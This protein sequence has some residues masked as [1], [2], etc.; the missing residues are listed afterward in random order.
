MAFQTKKSVLAVTVEATE[1]TYLAPSSADDFLPIQEDFSVE[2]AFETLEN[3]ELTGSIGTAKPI[4]GFEVPTASL[5]LYVK[6]SA[7]EGTAPDA[8]DL[9]HAAFGAKTLI[10]SAFTTDTG[11]TT[12]TA[13]TRAVLELGVGQGASVVRGMAFYIPGGES[14]GTVAIRNALSVSTDSVTLAQNLGN[15][16]GSGVDVGQPQLYRAAGIDDVFPSLSITDYRANGGAVQALAGGRVTEW[17]MEAAAGALINGSFSLE[18]IAA[19][20]NPLTV[21]ATD[22]TIDW[23]DDGGTWQA[24]VAQKTYKDPLDLASALETAMNAQTAETIAVT[25]SKT[26]GKYTI[27]T[28]TSAVLSLLWNTGA[29]AANTIG[30]LLG[31]SVAADDTGATSYEADNA[32]DLSAQFTP[33]F[34]DQGPLVAK[35]NQVLIGDD[36][37]DLVCFSTQSI[38]VTLGDE[39]ADVLD[40]CAESGKSGSVITSRTIT[41]DLVAN[42]SQFDAEKFKNFRNNDTVQFTYTF[43]EKSGGNWVRGKIGNLFISNATITAHT[44][45]DADGLVVLNLSLQGFVDSGLSEVHLNFL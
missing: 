16:P 20:Y 36:F 44:L 39:K 5:S 6:P 29:G 31:Y 32:L 41:V 3:A 27:S 40:V 14:D 12:G 42:L 23:T 17:T 7:V 26:T 15:A 8:D 13:S 22:N 21:G 37:N 19:F 43:G 33:S 45:D 10:G 28:S 35:N 24:T 34:D 2:A 4:Q 25:Y 18:G 9:Y 1:G 11:S 30:D 38:S